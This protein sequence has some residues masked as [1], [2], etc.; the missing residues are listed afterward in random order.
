METWSVLL[1]GTPLTAKTAARLATAHG[2]APFGFDRA[3]GIPSREV[4]TAIWSWL[5]DMD[6]HGAVELRRDGTAELEVVE[7]RPEAFTREDLVAL[8]LD[9]LRGEVDTG[10]E[11]E[12]APTDADA[13]RAVENWLRYRKPA[14]EATS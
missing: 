1:E 13:E 12:D 9:V 8:A 5:Y 11:A 7:L 4:A 6:L 10:A 14:G 2:P 3:E